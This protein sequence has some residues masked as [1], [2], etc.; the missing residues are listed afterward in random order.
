MKTRKKMLESCV[1]SRLLSGTQTWFPK[2]VQMKKLKASWI[3]FLRSMVKGGFKRRNVPG[4]NDEEIEEEELDYRYVYKNDRIQRI[5]GSPPLEEFANKQYLKYIGHICREENTKL[6]KILL[7]SKPTKQYYRD[8]W[9]KISNLLG[10]T[11]E[12]A[13]RTTQSRK[14]FA[15]LVRKCNNSTS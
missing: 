15:E 8:P 1:R 10:V 7:F 6:T 9:H 2:E 14:K 12:Q 11:I 5:V 3:Q 13:K 4:R